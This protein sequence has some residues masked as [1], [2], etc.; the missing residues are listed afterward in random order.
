MDVDDACIS[1]FVLLRFDSGRWHFS[2]VDVAVGCF[3]RARRACPGLPVRCLVAA[4]G[5]GYL[6][7]IRGVFEILSR[8]VRLFIAVS[9]YTNK[10][11][12]FVVPLY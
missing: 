5:G 8:A 11:R 1:V 4:G 7:G 3:R 6:G 9:L 12:V 10:Q 2:A